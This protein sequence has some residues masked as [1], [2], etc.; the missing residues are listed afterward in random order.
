MRPNVFPFLCWKKRKNPVNLSVF[1]KHNGRRAAG[2]D[3]RGTS[4]QDETNSAKRWLVHRSPRR[5]AKPPA[6][7]PLTLFFKRRGFRA[8]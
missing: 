6:R 2:A 4:G 1:Q 3:F 5:K 7:S 8:G